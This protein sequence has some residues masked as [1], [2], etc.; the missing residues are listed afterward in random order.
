MAETVTQSKRR[1]PKTALVAIVLVVVSFA[2]GLVLG[3]RSA[4]TGGALTTLLNRSSS[5]QREISFDLFWQVWDLLDQKFVQ[6]P[7]DGQKRF[8]GAIKGMVSSL[9]DPYTAFMDPDETKAFQNDLEGSF[10]GIGIEIGIRNDVLTVIA[11]IDDSPAARAGI[12]AGDVILK[13]DDTLSSDLSLNEAVQ[14]IRGEKGT[15]VR[16][17][18]V[19]GKD[20]PFE[21][22]VERDNI[23]VN[24]VKMTIHGDV[25]VIEISRFGDTTTQE[26]N[27][28]IDDLASKKVKGIVVD[29]RNNP[30]G[31][32]QTAIEVGS[33][34]IPDGTIV[35]E[36]DS[37]GNRTSFSATGNAK[38]KDYP[39]AVLINQGSASAAEILAGALR[40]RRNAPVVGEKSFGKGS[41]QEITQLSDG[42]SVRITVAKWFTPNGD[43]IDHDGINPSEAV[44]LSDDDINHS[45]DP[46]LD[47][48]LS[49]VGK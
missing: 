41:V 19:R 33:M 15:T 27:Q 31:F 37:K 35:Q 42:S 34:F 46:Q 48:A 25:A 17:T 2:A 9:G 36:Q 20:K 23:S 47:K 8:Y 28:I 13:I 49:L 1:S 32:L 44:T 12:H 29:V 4:H 11:P 39:V 43:S 26:M 40:D 38:L 18:L 22:S 6:Q 14:K 24:S 45:R 16:L 21:V 7:V 3:N 5:Q 30:G 10:D